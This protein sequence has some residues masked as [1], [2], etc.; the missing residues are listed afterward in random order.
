V[1]VNKGRSTS[2]GHSYRLIGPVQLGGGGQQSK[3]WGLCN[4]N[5]DRGLGEGLPELMAPTGL[6][7]RYLCPVIRI[8]PK[9]TRRE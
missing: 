6:G 5:G 9:R 4:R 2:S 8:W 1:G 3:T 7:E